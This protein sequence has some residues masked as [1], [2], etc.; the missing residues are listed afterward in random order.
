MICLGKEFAYRQMKIMA[1]TYPG[2]FLQVQTGT[3][4]HEYKEPTH[5]TMFTLHM[6]NKGLHL[7]AHTHVLHELGKQVAAS[8][9]FMH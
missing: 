7:Y 3:S 4:I 9:S 8:F 1:V 6:D 2:S 5:K